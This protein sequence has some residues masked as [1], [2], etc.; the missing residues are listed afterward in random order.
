[1]SSQTGDP[2]AATTRT[3]EGTVFNVSGQDWDSVVAGAAEAEDE[4]IAQAEAEPEPEPAA[5]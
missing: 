1:M 3:T 4:R 2:Y 5:V